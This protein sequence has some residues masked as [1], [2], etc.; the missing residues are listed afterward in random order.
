[1]Q[2]DFTPTNNDTTSQTNSFDK[3]EQNPLEKILNTVPPESEALSPS[4]TL[5]IFRNLSETL[6]KRPQIS[7]ATY[8]VIDHRNF[9]ILRQAM[10]VSMPYFRP[11]EK[12]DVLNAIQTLSIPV[13]D[14]VF[15]AVLS[16]LLENVFN[17]SLN[18]V[19]I[20]DQVLI[21]RQKNRLALELHRNLIDRFNTRTSQLPIGFSYF[22]RTR[23]M[24]QFIER[25]RDE[26]IDEVFVNM[27]KCAAKKQQI[28]ILT[29][30]EA[31]DIIITL[32]SFGDKCEY[33]RTV[34]DKAFDIWCTSEVTI[35]MA[36]IV[37]TFLVRR[38]PI[39]NHRL[40]NDPRFIE[41]CA[42]VAI[43]NG[44]IAKCFLILR[45]LNRLVSQCS[46]QI[47]FNELN[48][49]RMTEN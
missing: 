4:D 24:L 20:L 23:R 3:V 19:M 35:Q 49:S 22:M 43:A 21:S 27:N 30:Y 45:H 2:S 25:N 26:I 28:D 42:Q 33:F 29:A 48:F 46:I 16:S 12:L 5:N 47:K 31:M 41:T 44:D 37:I 38:K 10:K 15:N 34:L 17:M 7:P 36:E 40:F 8:N 14:D 32:S 1:M 9:A 18:E 39:L 13:D 11:N 6:K